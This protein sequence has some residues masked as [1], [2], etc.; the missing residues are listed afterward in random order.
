MVPTTPIKF[1]K[2]ETKNKKQL[3]SYNFDF[4]LKN[5]TSANNFIFSAFLS[6]QLKTNITA[7]TQNEIKLL[8]N[9]KTLHY[10]FFSTYVLSFLENYLNKKIW[11]KTNTQNKL[12]GFLKNYTDF[13][14]IKY[15]ANYKR[16][17]KLLPLNI[18]LRLLVN[19]FFTKDLL[20]FLMFV[21]QVLEK[22][23]FK[24]HKKI[25]SLIFELLNKN[26]TLSRKLGVLGFSFDIRG[27]VGVS[28]NAKKR[29]L[30]FSIGTVT[31][32]T[33]QIKS[34]MQQINI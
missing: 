2:N 14:F 32:T 24:N 11:V 31:K 29:H 19:M 16:V 6:K 15:G 12:Y 18:F 8:K 4:F 17:E 30:F 1:N 21:K 28:G 20:T 26:Q 3:V 10:V 22:N 34:N 27:K 13:F 9:S 5:E 7:H 23:H 25:L 33:Q